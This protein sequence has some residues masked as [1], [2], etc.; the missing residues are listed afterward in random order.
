MG[1]LFSK[2]RA[3]LT[4]LRKSAK[5]TV[6]IIFG[7]SVVPM[8]GLAGLAIDYSSVS[9]SRSVLQGIADAATLYS[10]SDLIVKP[11]VS[12]TEQKAASL[13]AVKKEFESLVDGLGAKGN[14]SSV[15][16]DATIASNVITIKTCY[17]GTQATTALNMVGVSSMTFEG[18]SQASSAPPLYVSVYVLADASGSM[19]VGATAEAQD[20]MIAKLGC[21]FAC[22]TLNWKTAAENPDCINR[23]SWQ[24]GSK[25]TDCA[26]KIGVQTRFDVIKT[27]FA[28][29]TEQAQAMQKIP[30]QFRF[31][32]YKFS[33]Q[34]T[35]VQS[36][37]T[38]FSAT[39]SAIMNMQPDTVGAGSN[40]R[41]AFKQMKNELPVSGDGKS[42]DTPKVF[43]LL[44]TDGVES[45]VDEYVSCSGSGSSRVCRTNGSWNS[46]PNF[47]VN[48]T[49]FWSGSERSQAID[50][51]MCNDLKSKGVVI[52]TLNTEYFVSEKA[53][54]SDGRFA[55]IK[56]DLQPK[57]RET[58]QKCATRPDLAFYATTP[59]EIQKATSA[60]FQSLMEKARII[61]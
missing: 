26:H 11:N 33:N 59:G 44:M 21:A 56:S 61:K 6:T 13:A 19:G 40:I 2:F 52:A 54:K 47:T 25:T 23:G 28:S 34:I 45:N 15:T 14:L 32:V 17:V 4:D 35:K 29:V 48:S 24:D 30:D 12:W 50:P 39:K 38:S 10:V 57:I 22:H 42:A 31:G 55:T 27:A 3:K 18:C 46:D 1:R 41:Y 60:M 8:M 9:K 51:A 53:A 7:L 37:T 58:M 43:L 5:G 49:G 16:Y 20:I 36:T